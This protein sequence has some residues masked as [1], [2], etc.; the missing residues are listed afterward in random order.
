MDSPSL[1]RD[2][3]SD[4]AAADVGASGGDKIRLAL[5]DQNLPGQFGITNRTSIPLWLSDTRPTLDDLHDRNELL[6]LIL[7][8]MLDSGELPEPTDDEPRAASDEAWRGSR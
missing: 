1:A 8:A 4:G 7:S 6:E 3:R 2:G 5:V